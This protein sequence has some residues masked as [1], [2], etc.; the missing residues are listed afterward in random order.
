MLTSQDRD[1]YQAIFLDNKLAK[2]FLELAEISTIS[3]HLIN[4]IYEFR[5]D[6]LII[7]KNNRFFLKMYISS[8]CYKTYN[9]F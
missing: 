7:D 8:I 2:D 1:V 5:W 4:A 9:S 6:K 3:W